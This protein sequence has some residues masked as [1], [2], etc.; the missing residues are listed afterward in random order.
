MYV[1]RGLFPASFSLPP[2]SGLTPTLSLLPSKFPSS[3]PALYHN[4]PSPRCLAQQHAAKL[5][6]TETNIFI[7]SVVSSHRVLK[8]V[9]CSEQLCILNI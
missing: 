7:L 8:A 3:L 1:L 6:W 2:F 9:Y 5:A 4:L